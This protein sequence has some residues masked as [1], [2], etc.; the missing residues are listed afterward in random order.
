MLKG[1]SKDEAFRIGRE[2]CDAVTADNPK[3]VKLK[4]E[5]VS[6]HS[7][8]LTRRHLGD[9]KRVPSEVCPLFRDSMYY[10]KVVY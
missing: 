4:F 7:D 10:T 9:V 6:V 5:K 3:P 1:A 2:I 8:T